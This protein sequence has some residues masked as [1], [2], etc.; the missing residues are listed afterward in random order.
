MLTEDTQKRM[1]AI[2]TKIEEVGNAMGVPRDEA[3]ALVTVDT[4][5]EH[6]RRVDA[7]QTG[8]IRIWAWFKGV[9]SNAAEKAKEI[10]IE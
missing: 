2:Q 4:M 8:L 9:L 10:R 1:R 6:V 3:A 5:Q 7:R